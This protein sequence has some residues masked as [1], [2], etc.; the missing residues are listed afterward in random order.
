[1]R[2]LPESHDQTARRVTDEQRVLHG[3]VSDG[4]A[5]LGRKEVAAV[6]LSLVVGVVISLAIG[7]P[8]NWSLVMAVF[9]GCAA[10]IGTFVMASLV[11]VERD[12]GRVND[13]AHH[14]AEHPSQWRAQRAPRGPRPGAVTSPASEALGTHAGAT[15]SAISRWT[16][17]GGSTLDDP[18]PASAVPVRAVKSVS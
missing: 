17:D 11:M 9:I 3:G 2:T 12:D 15:A 6:T 8:Q 13:Q 10:A 16:D 4:V 1:M 18:E 14:E 7:V 5:H